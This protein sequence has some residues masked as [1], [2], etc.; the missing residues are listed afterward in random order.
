MA[1]DPYRWPVECSD[2][3]H[4]ELVVRGKEVP[5]YCTACHWQEDLAQQV[6]EGIHS[7]WTSYGGM[8]ASEL[9]QE[10]AR[11]SFMPGWRLRV[12]FSGPQETG[13]PMA[14]LVVET[15]MP[16]SYRLGV[17]GPFRSIHMVPPYVEP[18]MFPHWMLHAFEHIVIHE[19]HEWLK[20]D[21][22]HVRDPHPELRAK[23]P[24]A[25]T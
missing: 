12:Q 6:F 17:E 2:N 10:V 18:E 24:A 8:T 11:Y 15:M 4:L 5:L 14:R 19:C 9:V 3:E 23:A 22:V 25:G 20:R 16:D 1:T 13:M 21:G 7:G